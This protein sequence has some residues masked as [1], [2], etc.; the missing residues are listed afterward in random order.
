[1]EPCEMIQFMLLSVFK[2]EGFM[3][4]CK[5]WTFLQVAAFASCGS[6]NKTA[7]TVH[8]KNQ[9]KILVAVLLLYFY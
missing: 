1:M 4:T 3:L 2:S 7:S 5:L 6:A 8:V 9:H